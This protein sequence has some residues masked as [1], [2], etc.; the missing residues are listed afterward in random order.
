M[1][2]MMRIVALGLAVMVPAACEST[3]EGDRGSVFGL[4]ET[5]ERLDNAQAPSDPFA[6]DLF[7]RYD[8][9]ARTRLSRRDYVDADYFARKAIAAAQ[10]QTVLPESTSYWELESGDAARIDA[11]RAKLMSALDAGARTI[12]PA[13]AAAAQARFDCMVEA[14]EERDS[15]RVK[16]CGKRFVENLATIEKTPALKAAYEN[17]YRAPVRRVVPPPQKGPQRHLYMVLFDFD[18]TILSNEAKGKLQEIARMMKA[19][20]QSRV[21]I[22]GHADAS[23]SAQ[24]NLVLSQQRAAAVLEELVAAGA[25]TDR[26][27]LSWRGEG[28]PAV[29][30]PDGTKEPANRRVLVIIDEK[31]QI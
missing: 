7:K 16:D 2:T 19:W 25:P 17:P 5:M 11:Q 22:V 15:T 8:A 14:L 26:V 23:G 18:Q 31:G 6:R 10:G 20:P 13:P 27:S 24:Y 9:Y 4:N 30:R 12:Q 21:L 1:K 29:G 3:R 28:Q